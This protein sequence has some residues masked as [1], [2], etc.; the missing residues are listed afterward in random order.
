PPLGRALPGERG[1][2]GRRG[3]H[4]ERDQDPYGSCHGWPP[5]IRRR[6]YWPTI[7]P[8]MP[9]SALSSS[10]F[11]WAPTLNLSRLLTR[12]S[13][14][15]LNSA[16]VIFMPLWEAFMVWPLYV[17][18]PPVASQIWSTSMVL[19]CGMFAS[20]KRLLMRAS[21]ATLPMKSSTTAVIAGLPPSRS[22]RGFFSIVAESCPAQPAASTRTV[23]SNPIVWRHVI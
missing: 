16:S 18:G 10:F 4:G 11:S 21:P 23:P 2:H 13:T 6:G 8:F 7:S 22:Y 17:Q 1:A 9:P 5:W 15:A 12:S 19:S 3:E 14:R 20:A